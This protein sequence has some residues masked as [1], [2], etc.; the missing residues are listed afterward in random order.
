M[1]KYLTNNEIDKERWDE[2]IKN[3]VNGIVY[4]NS[5]Y[6]DIVADNWNALVENNYER[7]FPLITGYKWGIPYLYQP[8]FSQ[9]LGVFSQTI[10]TEEVVAKFLDAIPS[11][12]KFAEI[13]L[14]SLN[15]LHPGKY[16]SVEWINHELD[17]INAYEK[18]LNGFSTNLKRKIKKAE[19]SGIS[20]LTNVKPE[21]IIRIF[22]ENKG[23]EISNLKEGDYLK[24]RRLAYM[25]IYKGLIQTYGVYTTKNELCA[26][27]IFIKSKRKTIFLF[28][29]LTVEGRELNA[30][31][32]LISSFIKDH[33]QHHITLDFEGSNDPQLARFYKS[34]GSL[35][36]TYPHLIINNLPILLKWAVRLIKY[37]R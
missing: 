32:L 36:C 11:Q 26:G 23:K 31:A 10:L 5:W 12:F 17:L 28:S 6:L 16:K 13:N 1:I 7:V 15:K 9:Q 30:M 25:G 37:L 22:K 4:A 2:C 21:E 18:T 8:V 3:A 27:A 14:N 34:F 35:T 24:L 19:K 29:G 20:L 33:S